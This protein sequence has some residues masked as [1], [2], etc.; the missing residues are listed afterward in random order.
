MLQLLEMKRH[1][2]RVIR[3]LEGELSMG[4]RKRM[5]ERRKKIL[6]MRKSAELRYRGLI[7][8]LDKQ[9]YPKSQV[10][11]LLKICIAS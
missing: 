7:Q 5:E 6:M 8:K 11:E 2:E 9:C 10:H 4:G 1:G 3:E